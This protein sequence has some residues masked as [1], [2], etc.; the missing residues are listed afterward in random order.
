MLFSKLLLLAPR[1]IA[2]GIEV[3]KQ[4]DSWES[5]APNELLRRF[6]NPIL[7]MNW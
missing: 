5:V 2:T 1:V 3:V 7:P 6:V 4:T